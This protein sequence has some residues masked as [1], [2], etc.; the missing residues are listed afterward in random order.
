MA[1]HPEC[2]PTHQV[3]DP[4]GPHEKLAQKTFDHM[5]NKIAE[6]EAVIHD[7]EGKSDNRMLDNMEVA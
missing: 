1:K 7:L 2:G 3:E 5:D 6:L 4:Q